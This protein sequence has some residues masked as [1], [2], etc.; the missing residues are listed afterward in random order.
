MF[1][2]ID[3]HSSHCW[4]N[5]KPL[6]EKAK[7]EPLG[8][9]TRS[10]NKTKSTPTSPLLLTIR[11]TCFF[12]GSCSEWSAFPWMIKCNMFRT[13]KNIIHQGIIIIIGTTVWIE[14]G[15]NIGNV[16]RLFPKLGMRNDRMSGRQKQT[17]AALLRKL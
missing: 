12:G 6:C 9:K 8:L 10:L 5:R 17:H 11:V 16:F 7:P 15:N 13:P 2:F 4:P 1:I 14:R 3:T